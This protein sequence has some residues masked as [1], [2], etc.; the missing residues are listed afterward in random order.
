MIG[1]E[2]SK[3]FRRP[4]TW[5]TLVLLDA[6]PTVVAILL[7]TTHL[8][9]RPGQ[10]PAFLSAVLTNGSLFAVAALA[11]VLPLFLPIAVAVVAGESVA[12]EAQS[13]TLR[14]LLI[15]PIG[16]TKLLV[17]KLISVFAFVMAAV[18]LVAGTGFVVGRLLLGHQPLSAAVSSVSGSQLTPAQIA[19]RTLLAVG[20]VGVSMLGVA[21]M[22]LFLSTLT[23][24]AQS[25]TLGALAFL[26]GSSLLLTLDA[27]TSLQ[28]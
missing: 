1:V 10:G 15:R 5:L 7:A 2:L 24:S 20:Y 17:A 3:L 9:P 13:G 6:L 16:R 22:A 19:F 14:Y 25:A 27:A 11:I 18:V 4:R 8:G 26:I 21:A 12:G 28:P 23:D